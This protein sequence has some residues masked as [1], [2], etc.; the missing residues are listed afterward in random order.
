MGVRGQDKTMN[1]DQAVPLTSHITVS[2]IADKVI[3]EAVR[4]GDVQL[5]L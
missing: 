4:Y 3:A 1:T 2:M 5:L